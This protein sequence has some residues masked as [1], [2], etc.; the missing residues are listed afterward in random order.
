MSTPRRTPVKGHPGVYYRVN[1]KGR[2][3]YEI[4]YTDTEGKRRWKTVD[5]KLEDAQVA[6][7]D[8]RGRKRKG[9]RIAP[10]RA[11]LRSP[12]RSACVRPILGPGSASPRSA[13]R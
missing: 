1:A 10:T 11:T 7:D 2:R 9:E 3:R 5:G 6:L 8:V 4:S 12:C 13:S